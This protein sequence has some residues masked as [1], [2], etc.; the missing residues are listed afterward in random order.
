M[1][2][3]I[4]LGL[5][6]IQAQSFRSHT[7][8]GK[9]EH[10]LKGLWTGILDQEP[11]WQFY[12]EIRIAS[13]SKD[14][15]VRGTTY[16][17]SRKGLNSM[18]E[19]G[20]HGT[21]HFSGVLVKI[22]GNTYLDFQESTIDKEEIGNGM[23]WCI[24]SGRLELSEGKSGELFLKGDWKAKSATCKPGSVNV[25][26]VKAKE[27]DKTI[28]KYMKM[29]KEVGVVTDKTLEIQDDSVLIEIWD[30]FVED[31]DTVSLFLNGEW[32]LRN[33][34]ISKKKEIVKVYNLKKKNT[35]I[36]HAENLGSQPPNTAAIVVKDRF[37]KQKITLNSS[38]NKSEA[39]IIFR[40]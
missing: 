15:S 21:I 14:D 9:D 4:V 29:F 28:K 11:N 6:Q 34:R 30:E 8:E 39:V 25:K 36:L 5:N 20:F 3:F 27:D 2:S 24:K 12:F 16:I 40:K 23:Y 37:K 38:E 26:K 35:L 18:G 10:Q 31:G 19:P 7:L 1:I 17:E 33:H 22:G 32:V 13:I